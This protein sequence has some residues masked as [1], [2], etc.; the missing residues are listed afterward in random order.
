MSL[1][2]FQT[3]SKDLSLLQTN[4]A[5]QINPVLQIPLNSG[6]IL[7]NVSLVS[8]SNTINHKLGKKLQG[9]FIVRQRAAAEVY[10]LQD[11]NL[12]PELTLILNSNASVN[13]NLF[14]F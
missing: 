13:V 7:Q 10:D 11:S 12:Y 6:M 9:W 4:W 1:P 8:G 14:V 5:M 2:I 3:S